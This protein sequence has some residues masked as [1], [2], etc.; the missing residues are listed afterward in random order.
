MGQAMLPV[1]AVALLLPF[2]AQGYRDDGMFKAARGSG[3]EGTYHT[4]ANR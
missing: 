1:L 2:V 3:F 4:A